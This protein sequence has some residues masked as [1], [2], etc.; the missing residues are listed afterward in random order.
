MKKFSSDEKGV[1]YL[2]EYKQKISKYMNISEIQRNIDEK[3]YSAKLEYQ[4]LDGYSEILVNRED[5]LNKTNLINLQT[6]GVDVTHRN[7]NLLADYLRECEDEAE[8]KNTHTKLGFMKYSGKPIYKLY[9]A[10]GLESTY[11][12]Q[13]DIEPKGSEEEYMNMLKTEVFGKKELEFILISSLSSILLAYIGEDLGLDSM[14]I[15]LVGNS[16]TGKSTALKLAISCFG[17]PDVKKN[18]LFGTYNGTNNA[19]LKKLVG[20]KGVPYALDEISMSNTNNFTKFVYSL[21]NGTDKERLNKNSD[22]KEKES[23]LTTIL[24][25]GEKSI[26]RASNKNAGIQVR[27]IEAENFV[28]TK[29]SENA[30]VINNLILK[31]YGHLGTK[32]AKFL[33]KKDKKELI[34]QYTE[35][36]EMLYKEIEKRTIVDSMSVRRCNKFTIL[37]Q[38]ALLFQDMVKIELNLSG[39]INMII[40]IEQ[41][42]LKN[43]NFNDSVIDYIEQYVDKYRN[44]FSN[45]ASSS[46]DVL[47]TITE[48]NDCVEVQ[49]NKIS[50]EEMLKQGGYEDKNI[51]L[52][53]LK[54]G[55]FLNCEKDRYTR[56]RKNNL[57]YKTEVIVIRIKR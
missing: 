21:A 13:L 15:N 20:L 23:W 50:F 51:V 54:E 25:N 5:Y 22:L 40:K 37:L 31:N 2:K 34:R 27:V 46:V 33:L 29:S 56:T 38:T 32:F 4:S 53:E 24:S 3:T 7:V 16:T 26:I 18:G 11:V 1:Y 55:G 44:K 45:N 39:I 9:K 47:G 49:M 19:L 30:E 28:W 52:K 8:V 57:G 10:I 17:N 42:S 35:T 14:I 48:V 12:G 6:N 41:E 43:R 36:R